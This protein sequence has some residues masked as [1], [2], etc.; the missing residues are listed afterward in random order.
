[1]SYLSNTSY[2]FVPASPPL[3]STL[4]LE[5]LKDSNPALFSFQTPKG[6]KLPLFRRTPSPP[7]LQVLCC[8]TLSVSSGENFI[9]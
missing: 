8:P 5:C 3:D 6:S 7:P 9:I 4:G 2:L 1:M